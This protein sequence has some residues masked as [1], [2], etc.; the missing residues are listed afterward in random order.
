MNALPV[1]DDRYI[2]TKIRAHGDKVYTNFRGLNVSEDDVECA[3]F[4]VISI[5]YLLIYENKYYLQVYLDNYVIQKTVNQQMTDYLDENLK[6]R[7]YKCC[8]TKELIW[9][10]E[11]ILLKVLIEKND[12]SWLV[13]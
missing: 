12:F 11:L 4:T 2:K 8:I 10:K 7:C 3:S 6:I 1:Y 5:D 13:F 9:A